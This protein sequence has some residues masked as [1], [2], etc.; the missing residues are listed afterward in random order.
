MKPKSVFLFGAGA[1]RDWN[2]PSTDEITRAILNDGFYLTDNKTRLT[3]YIYNELIRNKFPANSI[4]FETIIDVLDE[5][6]SFYSDFDRKKINTSALQS[7][8][9]NKFTKETIFNY[10]DITP[11][12]SSNKKFEI[13]IGQE[14]TF[15][16]RLRNDQTSD[17]LYLNL[18]IQEIF[19]SIFTIIIKYAYK[20]SL[21]Y[22]S[23]ASLNFK[24]WLKSK[25]ESYSV[26]LYTLNYE[27]IFYCLAKEEGIDFF[28]GF[29]DF[30]CTRYGNISP[31]NLFKI[32]SD[33]D[34]NIHYNLH[35]SIYWTIV[36]S[37]IY[38]AE[39]LFFPTNQKPMTFQI[40]KGKNTI[41]SPII[42][43]YQKTHKISLSPFRQMHF[44]FD[45]DC[46]N[47]S[48]IYIFGYSFGDE[49][50]NEGIKIAIRHNHNIKIFVVD[51]GFIKDERDKY[52]LQSLEPYF[53]KGKMNY[54]GK[55]INDK[56]YEYFDGQINVYLM[57]F[58]EF[59]IFKNS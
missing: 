30:I 1:A 46:M 23:I 56:I 43:G 27:D 17:E 5:M 29:G 47:A 58:K 13:P 19:T 25:S 49:H 7:F 9:K 42:S 20:S 41:L 35:G 10:R 50:I 54:F 52:F 8:F 15:N 40:D 32:I 3:Q 28:N 55:K 22:N 45:R 6:A 14:Y 34:S 16:Y 53:S 51:P 24:K 12:G 31:P 11:E 59:L 2:G 39:Y 18:L 33:T 57:S 48:E 37:E 36:E 38:L 26:R 4:N 21:D 44:S